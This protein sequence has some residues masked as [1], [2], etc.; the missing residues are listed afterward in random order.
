MLDYRFGIVPLSREQ[1][2]NVGLHFR[3]SVVICISQLLFD[4]DV[5]RRVVH[6]L[7]IVLEKLGRDFGPVVTILPIRER[8]SAYLELPGAFSK[9][10][11]TP[12]ELLDIRFD[13]LAQLAMLV[14]FIG[15]FPFEGHEFGQVGPGHHV[16]RFTHLVMNHHR[17]C[18]LN[19]TVGLED[20][21]FQVFEFRDIVTEL[22]QLFL[23]FLELF[24]FI[25]DFKDPTCVHFQSRTYLLEL[26]AGLE[27][28]FVLHFFDQKQLL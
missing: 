9:L 18:A 8:R 24:D 17:Q 5:A 14:D 1:V 27:G 6:A 7:V 2:V 19:E 26:L 21:I 20:A 25:F 4:V 11:D 13:T 22:A 10:L 16:D 28:N 12:T 23:Y 3:F 15:L